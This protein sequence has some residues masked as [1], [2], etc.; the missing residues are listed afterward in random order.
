MDR[1]DLIE[2]H[3]K[4]AE[5][6]FFPD[7]EKVV[8]HQCKDHTIEDSLGKYTTYTELLGVQ[9]MVRDFQRRYTDALAVYAKHPRHARVEL[10]A[11]DKLSEPICL[12]GP[13]ENVC[14]VRALPYEDAMEWVDFEM[15]CSSDAES[16]ETVKYLRDELQAIEKGAA[17]VA[18]RISA[19]K[20]HL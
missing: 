7:V 6:P 19:V 3:Y 5:E 18:E 8:M 11:T 20:A 15:R 10:F 1:D 12:N 16:G 4:R 2:H 9:E 14:A 13:C 17:Y